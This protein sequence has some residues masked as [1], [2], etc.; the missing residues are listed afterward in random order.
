[1]GLI[2]C[3]VA[4]RRG[5]G[6]LHRTDMHRSYRIS[7]LCFRLHSSKT[8]LNSASATTFNPKICP[9]SAATTLRSIHK[10]GRGRSQ[11]TDC[12]SSLNQID[13]HRP[14][15]PWADALKTEFLTDLGT[16]CRALS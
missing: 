14:F 6:S 2:R 4:L 9:H 13:W 1:M 11:R 8:A 12:Q 5:D 16:D 15:L 3:R 7:L 10:T